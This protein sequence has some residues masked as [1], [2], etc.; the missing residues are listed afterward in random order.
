MPKLQIH[1]QSEGLG[2]RSL[3]STNKQCS[4]LRRDARIH[5]SSQSTYE[6]EDQESTSYTSMYWQKNHPWCKL[7]ALSQICSLTSLLR[8]RFSAMKRHASGHPGSITIMQTANVICFRN[9]CLQLSPQTSHCLL[10]YHHDSVHSPY[11]DSLSVYIT[12]VP[13]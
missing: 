5:L 8:C 1:V 13:L 11:M 4:V 7:D 3:Q 9:K 12:S 2:D 10:V 6:F